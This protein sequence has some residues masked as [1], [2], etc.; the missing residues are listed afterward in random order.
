M[1][2]VYM[3]S[4]IMRHIMSHIMRHIMRHIIGHI[5]GASR[6]YGLHLNSVAFMC[7]AIPKALDAC[8]LFAILSKGPLLHPS[9][10]H[11]AIDRFKLG[12]RGRMLHGILRIQ[13]DPPPSY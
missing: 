10:H 13:V 9:L 5:M 4:H 8:T 12:Q 11:I 7:I 2:M 1:A 3:V 6:S